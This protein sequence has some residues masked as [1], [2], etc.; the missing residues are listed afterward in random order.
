VTPAPSATPDELPD[1]PPRG[2]RSAIRRAAAAVA[3]E[4]IVLVVLGVLYGALGVTQQAQTRAGAELGALL[5]VGTGVLL[6]LL[7]RALDRRRPWARSPV[8]VV[9]LL[10]LL[11]GLSLMPTG[12]APAALVAMALAIVVLYALA[13][14]EARDALRR[15]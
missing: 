1:E 3:V 2:L 4:G 5:I 13:T 12:I 9:Q 11:T 6:L 14:Q 15:P 8:V 7:A 10:A